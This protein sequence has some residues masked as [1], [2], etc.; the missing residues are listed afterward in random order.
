MSVMA[1]GWGSREKAK[2]ALRRM[3]PISKQ[4]EN[5][6]PLSTVVQSDDEMMD[7]KPISV[8]SETQQISGP[9]KSIVRLTDSLAFSNSCFLKVIA[10]SRI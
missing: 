2:T 3:H 4:D 8:S 7:A 5:S 9:R 6:M 10:K 1:N